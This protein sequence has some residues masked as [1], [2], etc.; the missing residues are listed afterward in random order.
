MD[1]HRKRLIDRLKALGPKP[2]P[3]EVSRVL[4]EETAA[5]QREGEALRARLHELR[6]QATPRQTDMVANALNA[7]ASWLARIG[8]PADAVAVVGLVP[9]TSVGVWIPGRAN[10]GVPPLDDPAIEVTEAIGPVID[11]LL[12]RR[13]DDPERTAVLRSIAGG[14]PLQA[15]ICPL[16]GGIVLRLIT[17]D[18]PV[19]VGRVELM[20]E[21]H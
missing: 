13:L 1:E 2:A 5:V 18:G 8:A 20:G 9:R 19:E 12:F 14:A 16:D 10:V 4:S 3:G 6:A 17:A 7:T 21:Q 15:L 11:E